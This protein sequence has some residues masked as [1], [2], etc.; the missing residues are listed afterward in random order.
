VA[1]PPVLIDIGAS[2]SLIRD[3]KYISKYSIC[4]AFDADTRD[5]DYTIE[6]SKEWH[7]LF[8]INKIV[9]DTPSHR[10]KFF[11]TKSPYC[12][13]LLKPLIDRSKN[14]AFHSLFEIDR[15]IE[16]NTINLLKVLEDLQISQIDWFKCDSQGT[17]LRL[18]N[19]LGDQLINKVLV[20]EFEPGFIDLYEGEDKLHSILS[21]MENK[22]F[23]LSDFTISGTQR[24]NE[25]IISGYLS[26]LQQRFISQL[27]KISPGWGNLCY[28]NTINNISGSMRTY[29]LICLFGIIKK[30]WGFV[31]EKCLEAHNKY[32]A[33]IFLTIEFYVKRRLRV[34]Y[35]KLFVFLI[36]KGVLKTLKLTKLLN[37]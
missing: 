3:W 6:N 28:L 32:N 9:T 8:V 31:L 15:V 5:M 23:W 13:S 2:G 20:A 35:L 27:I 12:S 7:K 10:E 33:D 22:S 29:L 1:N 21:Y 19:S 30:Q 37:N 24:I 18:F 36:K 14:W 34:S 16:M 11:L 25:K 26:P 4:I 17:D